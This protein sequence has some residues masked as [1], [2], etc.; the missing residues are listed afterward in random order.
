MAIRLKHWTLLFLGMLAFSLTGHSQPAL[1]ESKVTNPNSDLSR[2]SR[3]LIYLQDAAPE[4][5]TEFARVALVVLARAHETEVDLALEEAQKPEGNPG[6]R[7]WASSVE[8][9]SRQFSLLLED[10]ELGF[11]V[12][13][14]FSRHR[15][16]S[17]SVAD[18][19]VILTHPRVSGQAVYEQAVLE[20][21]CSRKPCDEYTP[22]DISKNP[23]ALFSGNLRPHWMF[24][25]DGPVCS[26]AGL[27]LLFSSSAKLATARRFCKASIG[28]AIN[29]A[30]AIAWQ[31]RH[32]VLVDWKSLQIE[33]MSGQPQHKVTLNKAGDSVVLAVP[34]L[35]STGALFQAMLPWIKGRAEGPNGVEIQVVVEDIAEI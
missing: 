13:V 21:F 3:T 6:L 33:R 4:L 8:L 28:E 34:V 14:S 18:R 29:L 12:L 10:L 1:E 26:H 27:K 25:E 17:L 16:A 22:A 24:T 32:A 30:N 9:Y 23:I 35:Y 31:Q 2:F 20:K 11:P 5:Q 7:A 15:P 19:T